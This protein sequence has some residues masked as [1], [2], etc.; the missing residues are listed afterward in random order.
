MNIIGRTENGTI[1]V[2][3]DDEDGISFVPDNMGNRHRFR[4]WDEWEMG[5]VDPVTGERERINTIPP[6]EHPEPLPQPLTAR[7]LR[8]GLIANGFG[9]G[10][11]EAAI[12][13]IEDPQQ[14]AVAQVEWEYAS[15]FERMHPLIAQVGSALGLMQEQIDAM[16]Q[17]ALSL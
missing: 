11:V 7:H 17:Q 16:W 10:Q 5:P 8:L 1:H 14:R 3:F 15:Q 13:A 6:L 12:A 9:L 4:I 2:I